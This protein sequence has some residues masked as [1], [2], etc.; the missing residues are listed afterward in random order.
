MGF[1]FAERVVEQIIDNKIIL[2]IW[3][4]LYAVYLQNLHFAV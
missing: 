3:Q 4:N 2:P 1:V